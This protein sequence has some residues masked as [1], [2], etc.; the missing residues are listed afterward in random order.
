M[1]DRNPMQ[2]C[3]AK[4]RSGGACGRAPRANGRCNLHGGKSTG[5]PITTGRDAKYLR[6]FGSGFAALLA[7]PALLDC[8]LEVALFDLFLTERAEGLAA[9]LSG[10]WVTE[11]RAALPALG[12]AINADPGGPGAR[13][14]FEAFSA[15]V[16]APERCAWA[17]LLAGA[18][19]RAGVALRADALA[20]R[21]EK[22]PPTAAQ[23][24]ALIVAM[25]EEARKEL[26]P[27]LAAKVTAR[28][29]VEILGKLRA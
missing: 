6:V 1:N 27:D 8:G 12:A 29:E 10:R 25:L 26:P 11:L 19:E 5:R 4:N 23:L 3:G 18:K 28:V 13:R 15:V 21:Q 20:V 14:A 7:D 22:G 2:R 9:G 24:F 16:D 17:E